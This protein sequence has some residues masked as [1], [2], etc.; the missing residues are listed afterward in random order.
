MICDYLVHELQMHP[1]EAIQ[2]FEEGRKHRIERK[3]YRDFLMAQLI[4][5]LYDFHLL[6]SIR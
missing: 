3:N 2:I 4:H 5:E 6:S 1:L